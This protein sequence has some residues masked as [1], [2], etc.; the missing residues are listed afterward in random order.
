MYLLFNL[1]QLS[2][3]I[4]TSNSAS[5]KY[6]IDVIVISVAV[7]VVLSTIILSCTLIIIAYNKGIFK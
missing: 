5:V 7:C 4:S 6:N 2:V 1:L 3:E